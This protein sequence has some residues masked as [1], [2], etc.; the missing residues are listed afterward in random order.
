[1]EIQ[2]VE[3]DEW[4][5]ALPTDG[6]EVF[7]TPEALSVLAEHVSGELELLA[8]FKGDRPVALL[9]VVVNR[10]AVGKAVLSPPPGMGIPRLGPLLMPASP[11]RRKQEQ[12]N[13]RFVGAVL[14]R[15]DQARTGTLF[16][17]ICSNSYGDPRPFSWAGLSVE[18][19]FTYRLNTADRSTEEILG[20]F[21]KSLRRE[22]RTGRDLD[23]TVDVE[24]IETA[25]TIHEETQHRYE[26]QGKTYTLDWS[27][28]HDLVEALDSVDRCRVYVARNPDGG[29]LGGV[30]VLSSND[31]AYFWQGGT[32]TSYENVSVNSLLHWRIIEDLVSDPPAGSPGYYD[33]MGANTE[34][35]CQYKSKFSASLI[36]YYSVESR[37]ATMT[38]AKR[39]YDVLRRS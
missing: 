20:A 4:A 17:A 37:G 13:Q 36:P 27:Y 34:R 19:S 30:T 25:E 32:R 3:M 39:L 31:A 22:I 24:G 26:E 5:E 1:M 23:L 7:H 11:K 29:F 10:S 14:E 16:R 12:L 15:Y 6:F 35:L 28:V 21:S 9:P 8:G 18:P 38:V 2:H 33:L